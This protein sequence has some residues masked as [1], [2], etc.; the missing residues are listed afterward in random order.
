MLLE[1]VRRLHVRLLEARS[2]LTD[3]VGAY[4]PARPLLRV[5]E[6]HIDARNRFEAEQLAHREH[7]ERDL[8]PV[9]LAPAR[10]GVRAAA[11]LVVDDDGTAAAGVDA[12]DP[13]PD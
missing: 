11:G 5:R 10:N 6:R 3:G 4:K 13:P 12:V 2:E 8:E 1:L 7:V 9:V